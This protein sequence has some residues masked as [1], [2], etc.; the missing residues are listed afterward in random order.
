MN[1]QYG[2]AAEAAGGF[3]C[4][5]NPALLCEGETIRRHGK[6]SKLML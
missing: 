5:F 6:V 4:V 2:A 3:G 1:P